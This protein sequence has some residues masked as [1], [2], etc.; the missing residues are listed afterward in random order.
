[1]LGG[2]NV[3]ARRRRV[4][5][6]VRCDPPSILEV[7]QCGLVN[8][9]A[10][11]AVGI[12]VGGSLV[13][14]APEPV[15]ASGCPAQPLTVG[16]LRGLWGGEFA[17]FAGMTNPRGRACYGGSSV[18]VIGFVDQPEG[19]GGTSAAGIKPAWLTEWGLLLYGASNAISTD[20]ANDFYTI[21]IPPG[22]GDLNVH[23]ARRWVVVTAHFDDRRARTCRG[24]GVD[25]VGAKEA[26]RVCRSIL[27]L[28]SVSLT[29]AP[30]TSTELVVATEGVGD[31][32]LRALMF[33]LAAGIGLLAWVRR[34]RP[35]SAQAFEAQT[36]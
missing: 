8:C 34:R 9:F 35:F 20:H 36:R 24:W 18:R 26:V 12:V 23:Y 11:I 13:G 28:S 2:Q 21:A 30:D 5:G 17:G 1:M 32:P 10:A 33:G 19:V 22:L 27:V 25:H 6:Q 31:W 14:A 7:P 4:T 3:A 15:L 29:S 16:E